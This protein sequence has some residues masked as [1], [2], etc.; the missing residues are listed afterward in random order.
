MYQK[1][2][3]VDDDN[4]FILLVTEILTKKKHQVFSAGTIAE[5]LV[6]LNEKAPD[7]V[8]LDNQLPDGSGWSKTEFILEKYPGI[9]LNL[10]SGLDVPKTT[11]TSFR[12]LEKQ[13]MLDELLTNF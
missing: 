11:T 13:Q 8:F 9:Q 7:V 12:I 10:M 3:I 2:L 5:G 4:D 1:I 6:L